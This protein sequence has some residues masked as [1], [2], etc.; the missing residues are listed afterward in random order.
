M[1]GLFCVLSTDCSSN[2]IGKQV[3]TGAVKK[4]AGVTEIGS[5]SMGFQPK[6]FAQLPLC[7]PLAS[8]SPESPVFSNTSKIMNKHNKKTKWYK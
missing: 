4:P 7:I 6:A 5:E 8:E 1:P 3:M 2:P